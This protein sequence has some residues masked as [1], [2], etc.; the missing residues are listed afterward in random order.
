MLTGPCQDTG[1]CSRSQTMR[2][3]LVTHSVFTSAGGQPDNQVRT[4]P[5]SQWSVLPSAGGQ[6]ILTSAVGQPILI[7]ASGQPVLTSASD[8]MVFA[9]AS[10]LLIFTLTDS[11][12]VLT[13]AIVQLVLIS[14]GGQQVL[15]YVMPFDQYHATLCLAPGP[16]TFIYF[17]YT[18]EF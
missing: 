1:E 8:Q 6:Q 4:G 17:E 10:G 7:L 14:A 3:I 5:F 16:C 15:L 9:S 2:K 12:P 11:Q 13:S 18:F